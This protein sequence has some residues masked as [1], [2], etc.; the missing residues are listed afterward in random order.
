M[1]S[2][3][4]WKVTVNGAGFFVEAIK[5]TT[6]IDYA[7]DKY[8]MGKR[9]SF[10]KPLNTHFLDYATI[11]IEPVGNEAK[12]TGTQEKLST[13]GMRKDGLEK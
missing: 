6:A 11:T 9:T 2:T 10:F 12:Q 5:S 7:M 13:V 8:L 3:K 1:K 4:P